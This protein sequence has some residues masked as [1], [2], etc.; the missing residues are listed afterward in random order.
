MPCPFDLRALPLWPLQPLTW[1]EAGLD[2]RPLA[3]QA[4]L[5][6]P[7]WLQGLGVQARQAAVAAAGV[8]ASENPQ[9]PPAAVQE[10]RAD[11]LALESDQQEGGAAQ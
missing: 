10:Q 8:A 1:T 5:V 2:G 3:A 6:L 4:S 7:C 11:A 9:A